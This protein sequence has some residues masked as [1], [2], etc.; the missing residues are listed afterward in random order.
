MGDPPRKGANQPAPNEED[1]EF[2]EDFEW[3]EP[4]LCPEEL[5]FSEEDNT[6]SPRR[7]QMHHSTSPLQLQSEKQGKRHSPRQTYIANGLYAAS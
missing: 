2:L 3:A 5:L 6:S 7:T 1:G 4:G